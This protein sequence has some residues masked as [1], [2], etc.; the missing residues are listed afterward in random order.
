VT[1]GKSY[2]LYYDCTL[3]SGT[4]ELQ[5]YTGSVRYGAFANATQGYI[6]FTATEDD[7]LKIVAT[8]ATGAADFDN[9]SLKERGVTE[10]RRASRLTGDLSEVWLDN[11][12]GA[13]VTPTAA[14]I[15]AVSDTFTLAD[16]TPSVLGKTSFITN[17]NVGI[18]TF[19]DGV[20]GQTIRV[21]VA[22]AVTT[23]LDGAT[24]ALPGGVDLAFGIGDVF[25]AIYR[26]SVWY[27]WVPRIE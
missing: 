7:N 15:A 9:F 13:E 5:S 25:E 18:T 26:S 12:V 20:E 4:F 8:S 23:L 17:S 27:V 6:E 2:R 11:I 1:T 22:D 3:T 24:L 19:D 10:Y 16:T 21:F 14:T